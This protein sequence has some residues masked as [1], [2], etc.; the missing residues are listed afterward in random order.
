MCLAGWSAAGPGF[1]VRDPQAGS[2]DPLAW[3][4]GS[5]KTR[6]DRLA[7]AAGDM[8]WEDPSYRASGTLTDEQVRPGVR[9]STP[10]GH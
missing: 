2:K 6:Q 1:D 5:S 10:A 3:R 8:V 7:A 9:Q 4:G